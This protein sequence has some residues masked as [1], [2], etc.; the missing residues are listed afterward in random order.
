MNIPNSPPAP[1]FPEDRA[2]IV[3]HVDRLQNHLTGLVCPSHEPGVRF[4]AILQQRPGEQTKCVYGP[5]RTE[6]RAALSRI[7]SGSIRTGLFS[8]ASS[9]DWPL[10]HLKKLPHA[11]PFSLPAPSLD[12]LAD[13]ISTAHRAVE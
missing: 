12:D 13:T 10:W 2:C 1:F 7:M 5:T 6:E 8:E 9:D 11:H 3:H 4:V